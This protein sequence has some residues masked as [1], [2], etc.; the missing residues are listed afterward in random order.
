MLGNV[1][2]LWGSGSI[3]ILLNC[4]DVCSSEE[5][6]LVELKLQAFFLL[7]WSATENL[8]P[9][10]FSLLYLPGSLYLINALLDKCLIMN[11]TDFID[12]FWHLFHRQLLF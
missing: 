10:S 7:W 4:T 6:R 1:N 11:F 2:M 9:S 12:R 3:C 8:H 5:F